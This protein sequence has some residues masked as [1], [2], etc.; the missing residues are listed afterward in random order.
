MPL[1]L[2]RMNR[3]TIAGGIALGVVLIILGSANN[4]HR[5]LLV[6]AGSVLLGMSVLDAGVY[7]IRNRS[8]LVRDAGD[9]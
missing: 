4:A 1:R 2:R 6:V 3:I 5:T 8:V 9:G 7:W